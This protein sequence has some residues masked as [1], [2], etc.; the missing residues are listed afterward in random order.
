M[1]YLPRLIRSKG[2]VELLLHKNMPSITPATMASDKFIVSEQIRCLC[3]ELYR[4][5]GGAGNALMYNF[6]FCSRL[7]CWPWV[8]L[9]IIHVSGNVWY[10]YRASSFAAAWLCM[11]E[12]IGMFCY[13]KMTLD[14][15]HWGILLLLWA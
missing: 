2:G 14:Q 12:H 6:C 13:T 15:C 3:C 9:L 10:A 8:L 11:G 7:F 1:T 4:N 5:V